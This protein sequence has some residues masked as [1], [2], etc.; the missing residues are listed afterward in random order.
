ML[1]SVYCSS[2]YNSED[3]EATYMSINRGI[4]KEDVVHRYNDLLVNHNKEKSYTNMDD[5]V[6]IILSKVRRTNIT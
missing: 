6:I 2:I 3:M 4:D 5:L 1:P